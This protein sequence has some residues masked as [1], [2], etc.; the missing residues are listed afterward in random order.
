MNIVLTLLTFGALVA[1]YLLGYSDGKLTARAD[2]EFAR[3][4][5]LIE[6]LRTEGK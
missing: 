6:R 1:V 5:E 2:H 4:D 3:L